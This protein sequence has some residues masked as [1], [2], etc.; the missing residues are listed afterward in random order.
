MAGPYAA[1]SI[2]AALYSFQSGATLGELTLKVTAA[3]CSI[4]VFA[5]KH[6]LNLLCSGTSTRAV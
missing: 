3:V 5:N 2:H 6:A 1:G 4:A